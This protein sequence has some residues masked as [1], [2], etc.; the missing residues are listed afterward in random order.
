MK[1]FFIFA[2]IFLFRNRL[3]FNYKKQIEGNLSQQFSLTVDAFKF[4]PY[5][6][7]CL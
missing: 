7:V 3:Q 2:P 5:T 6:N 1:L 4:Y